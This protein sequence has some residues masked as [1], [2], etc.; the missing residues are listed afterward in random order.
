MLASLI[1]SFVSIKLQ[2]VFFRCTSLPIEIA[3]IYEHALE[4]FSL[5]IFQQSISIEKNLNLN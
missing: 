4:T 2:W 1:P 3:L 5:Y